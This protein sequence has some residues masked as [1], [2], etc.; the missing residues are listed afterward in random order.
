LTRGSRATS[1]GGPSTNKA[2]LTST[3]MRS[4]NENTMSMS[5]SISSTVTSGGSAA[6]V[7]R[8]S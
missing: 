1:S 6:T 7:A 4:A 2:P 3:E 5:C 8:I